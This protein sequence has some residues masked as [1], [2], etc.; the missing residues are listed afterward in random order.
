[1]TT[2]IYTDERRWANTDP[3]MHCNGPDTSQYKH[4]PNWQGA[5]LWCLSKGDEESA[6]LIRLRNDERYAERCEQ[7]AASVFPARGSELMSLSEAQSER[8][9]MEYV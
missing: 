9:E 3:A 8:E 1:M 2:R 7:E 6:H 4:T 5:W